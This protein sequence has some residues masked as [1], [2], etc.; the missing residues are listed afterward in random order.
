MEVVLKAD[1]L[2]FVQTCCREQNLLQ[3]TAIWWSCQKAK[4]CTHTPQRAV[5]SLECVWE[6][7]QGYEGKITSR[8][9]LPSFWCSRGSLL[10]FLQINNLCG[11]QA[12]IL[13]CNV[14]GHAVNWCKNKLVLISWH[15]FPL[16][17]KSVQ[18]LYRPGGKLSWRMLILLVLCKAL[19]V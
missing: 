3:V 2:A 16:K 14:N 5:T 6:L 9:K 19:A 8:A 11:Y 17:L 12:N 18:W 15:L 1:C 10:V 13:C 7:S 4:A